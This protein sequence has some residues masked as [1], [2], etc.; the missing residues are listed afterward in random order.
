ME[1]VIAMR[2]GRV[3]GLVANRA[4]IMMLSVM[5]VIA[6]VS[7]TNAALA[8]PL[9][10][11]AGLRITS[12]AL[13]QAASQAEQ[14]QPLVERLI[15][16]SHPTRGGK[17][18]AQLA[19][20]RAD[21]VAGIAQV[22]LSVERRLADRS[23][24][25]RLAQPLALAEARVL[26]ARLAASGE[27]EAAEPDL[28]MKAQA[29]APND[30]AY[31]LDP[32]QWHYHAPS[33]A[34][35]G[36][37]NLP[38]AWEMTQGSG[39]VTVAVLDTGHR[40][41]ADLQSMLPGYDFISSS[42]VA[43]DGDGRDAD[44][45]DPGDHAPA[46]ACGSGSAASN[47]S[48]HGTHVIGTVAA[49]MNNGLY[50]TGVAPGVRVLPLRVLGRCGGYTSDI[51]D[52][53][54]WAAGIDVAGVPRNPNP[55]RVINLSLGSTG[56]CSAAFQSAIDD[57]NARGAMVVV[58]TGNGGYETINQP[59]NCSG[60]I[61]VT[62]HAIDGDS[63][64]YA[65]IGP[66]TLISAPGGGCGTLSLLCYPG[67]TADGPPVYSLGN[68]GL[69]V[70]LTDSYAYKLG[71]SM[72]APHV[73]GTIALMLSL[74]P[75]LSKAEVL[76]ML[77]SASRPWPQGSACTLPANSGLC[78][79]GLLD[80]R[81]ALSAAAPPVQVTVLSQ[82]VAPGA[83]VMLSGSV[84]PTAG[85]SIVSHAWRA[86]AS[87]PQPVSLWGADTAHAGFVAPASGRY[88]FTLSATDSAGDT[89]SATATVRV[90]SLP[91]PLTLPSQRVG[92]GARLLVQLQAQ[93]A[94]GDTLIYHAS[95]LPAGATLSPAGLLSWTAA[96]PVGTHRITWQ[97]SD[98]IGSGQ[99]ST[100][101]IE[102]IDSGSATAAAPLGNGA[103]GGGSLE[104]DAALML[105]LAGLALLRRQRRG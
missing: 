3:S 22:A 94:D 15:I 100:L 34:N 105:G 104:S 2:T 77:R 29:F 44:A 9:R 58:A 69:T 71:T 62:A 84:L 57:V 54:R 73:S 26:A 85:R 49:L 82:V 88:A 21:R 17:L 23:H 46:G 102:V 97:A 65:N 41:H 30:P 6:S 89:G 64:D 7:L 11:K 103:G 96:A 86:A 25:L 39:N 95:T 90:N 76:G 52:A 48:W 10:A 80:A 91:Q 79:A 61:A 38:A 75:A 19:N 50:G 74:N 43:L 81:L 8:A 12:Q 4:T 78:G 35:L 67:L 60:A 99:P 33:G 45:V 42:S 63:A 53:M 14:A 101:T 27:V 13:A 31:G 1:A 37:A 36:G 59:A 92:F 68:S 51:V 28:M 40:P 87:N 98:D 70:P 24:L 5:T 83:T 93:D 32:G 18:S 47:S 66:E 16:T 55:A 20:K 56:N 72:A